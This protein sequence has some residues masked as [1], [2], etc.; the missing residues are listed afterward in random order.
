MRKFL[1]LGAWIA[2]A[3]ISCKD[4]NT[5]KDTDIVYNPRTAQEGATTKV[6]DLGH[7][8]FIDSVHDFGK[9]KEGAVVEYSFD[10]TN[11]GK[12]PVLITSARPSCGCTASD[13]K[14]EAIQVGETG[15]IKV[16]FNSSGKKG[17]NRK[18]VNVSNNGY[19]SDI[20]L[21]I[22]AIVE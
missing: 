5:K 18:F 20:K 9:I 15:Q 14:Q 7:L 11:T 2:S 16:T 1:L 4:T 17:P 10:Y 8:S 13:Y 22:E 21:L 6:E 3:A 12:R 19:P